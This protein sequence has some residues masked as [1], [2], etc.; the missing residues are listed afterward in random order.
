[1]LSNK[2]L[3]RKEMGRRIRN[4]R[5][6]CGI[7]I[8]KLSDKIGITQSHLGLIERGERGVTVERMVEFCTFFK[9]TADY[10][11]T[12]KENMTAEMKFGNSALANS[13]DLLLNEEEKRKLL[14]FIDAIK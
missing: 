13:I 9:C 10:L 3:I 8:D 5:R 7:T 11:L 12:G 6:S 1:M 2:L 4:L 14:E